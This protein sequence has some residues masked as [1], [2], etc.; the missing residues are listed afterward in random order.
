M[1]GPLVRASSHVIGPVVTVSTTAPLTAPWL[2]SHRTTGSM[3][4]KCSMCV[5]DS[6]VAQPNTVPLTIL[7]FFLRLWFNHILNMVLI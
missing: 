2:S 7:G 5:F 4:V 1:T 3:K 6:N